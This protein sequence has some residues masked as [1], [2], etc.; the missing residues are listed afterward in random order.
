LAEDGA[1]TA[2]SDGRPVLWYQVRI[3]RWI[4]REGFAGLLFRLLYVFS[5]RR[6][7]ASVAQLSDPVQ[8]PQTGSWQLMLEGDSGDRPFI[9]LDGD[10]ELHI[11][12]ADAWF[13][14][15]TRE[16]DVQ[17]QA[18]HF[19]VI[20]RALRPG[21]RVRVIG[22][23]QPS[24]SASAVAALL[25]RWKQDGEIVARF[26]ADGDGVLSAEEF[27]A[28]RKAAQAEAAGTTGPA[29]VSA[30]GG[31]LLIADTA[32]EDLPDL[33]KL[34]ASSWGGLALIALALAALLAS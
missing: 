28:M 10:A 9:G 22:T 8:A 34:R 25:R 11:E 21:D 15:E 6:F 32:L 5:R 1:L 18:G 13:E 2:P 33:L 20:E 29:R 4:A 30:R 14:V 3:E 16:H 31:V 23:L 12:P 7:A 19:R 26:D 24:Q 17:T 27:A